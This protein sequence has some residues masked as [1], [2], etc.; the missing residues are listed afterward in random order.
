MIR[1]DVREEE[2]TATL[3]ILIPSVSRKYNC[4]QT[5]IFPKNGG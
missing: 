3:R 4:L 5:K 2:D 1:R